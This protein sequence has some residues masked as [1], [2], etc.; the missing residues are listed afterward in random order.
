MRVLHQCAATSSP[1]A[2]RV[3]ASLQTRIS[4]PQSNSGGLIDF[5]AASGMNPDID[6]AKER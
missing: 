1:C 5:R 2:H 3:S 4:T 6:V